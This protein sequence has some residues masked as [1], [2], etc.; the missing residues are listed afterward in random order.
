M[1]IL[2]VGLG[3]VLAAAA[4][5]DPAPRPIAI[6]NDADFALVQLQARAPKTAAWTFELL[7]KHSVG[8]GRDAKAAAPAGPACVYDLLATF[9]DGHKQQKL[10]VDTCKPGTITFSG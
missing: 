7:G 2:I 3:L 6:Y 10:A 9:D 4:L 5:A 1:R 8:V